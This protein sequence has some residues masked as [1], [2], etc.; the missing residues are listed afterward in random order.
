MSALSLKTEGG[1]LSMGS[2]TCLDLFGDV[3]RLWKPHFCFVSWF[4]VKLQPGKERIHAIVRVCFLLLPVLLQPHIFTQEVT[5]HSSSR[6]WA[7]FAGFPTSQNQLQCSSQRYQ[8]QLSNVPFLETGATV[9]RPLPSSSSSRHL[10]FEFR[11][12]PLS[13]SMCQ[14]IPIPFTPSIRSWWE[15]LWVLLSSSKTRY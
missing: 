5:V 15:P 1:C 4:P 8:H 9:L 7:H 10:C 13:V 3:L 14:F 2:F 11:A 6:S 12:S